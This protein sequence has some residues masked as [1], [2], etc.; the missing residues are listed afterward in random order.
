MRLQQCL[1]F[2]APE[3]C[4]QKSFCHPV[5]PTA[6][7]WSLRWNP[8]STGRAELQR[9]SRAVANSRRSPAIR[10]P[11]STDRGWACARRVWFELKL[12]E[13]FVRVE[14]WD[15]KSTG[16]SRTRY[17]HWCSCTTCKTVSLLSLPNCPVGWSALPECLRTNT[18]NAFE[19]TRSSHDQNY[20]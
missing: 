19:K 17:T 8:S 12:S 11:T 9:C 10:R 3:G 2:F 20:S 15:E 6:R 4:L 18:Q 16:L 1:T 5:R 14:Q 13:K 7:L